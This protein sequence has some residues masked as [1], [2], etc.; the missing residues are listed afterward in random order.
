MD[1]YIYILINDDVLVLIIFQVFYGEYFKVSA[2]HHHANTNVKSKET[3]TRPRSEFVIKKKK[4]KKNLTTYKNL[5]IFRI[6][7]KKSIDYFN[8]PAYN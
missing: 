1:I 7:P 3:K 6:H 4:K 5:I 8:F 2:L